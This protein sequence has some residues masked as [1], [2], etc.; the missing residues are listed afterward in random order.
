MNHLYWMHPSEFEIGE[1]EKR[2]TDMAA[3]GWELVTRGLWLDHYQKNEPKQMKYRIEVAAPKT[4]E[5]P[6]LPEEQIAVYADCGWE[7]VTG[8]GMIHV[9]CASADSDTEE[10]YL[11]AAQQAKTLKG[12]KNRYLNSFLYLPIYL[13]VIFGLGMLLNGMDYPN[14]NLMQL[15]L[16]FISET[17]FTVIWCILLLWS[18]VSSAYGAF[19]ISRLYHRMKRGIPLDHSPKARHILP[20]AVNGCFA[21]ALAVFVVLTAVQWAAKE[22]YDMP[23]MPDGP[24]VT[25]SILGI[26]GERTENGFNH[27]T[28]YVKYSR[29]LLCEYWD[30]F[31]AVERNGKNYWLYQDTYRLKDVKQVDTLVRA[32]MGNSAFARSADEYHP[33]QIEGLDAAYACGNLECIAVKENVVCKFTYVFDGSEQLKRE[34]SAVAAYWEEML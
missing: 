31:E 33:V 12:L 11:D 1:T 21:T 9:F 32:L 10:F 27:E 16:G 13:L 20:K 19:R 23:L 14:R 8:H 26:D 28:S 6:A 5:A 25:L 24:Y 4:F 22:T 30:T 3:K 7:Y 2:Y 34:L 18:I 15:Y 29:S 17:A